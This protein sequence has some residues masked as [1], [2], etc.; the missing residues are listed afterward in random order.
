LTPT[1]EIIGLGGGFVEVFVKT[2]DKDKL[3]GEIGELNGQVN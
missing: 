3:S 2:R 1:G